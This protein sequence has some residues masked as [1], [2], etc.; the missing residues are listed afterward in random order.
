MSTPK[1]D[2]KVT[3]KYTSLI[4]FGT[5]NHLRDLT[6]SLR[7]I[8]ILS[9]L[10]SHNNPPKLR[11]QMEYTLW[12]IHSFKKLNDM[13]INRLSTNWRGMPRTQDRVKSPI[14]R[15]RKMLRKLPTWYLPICPTTKLG[16]I[17]NVGKSGPS[18]KPYVANIWKSFPTILYV[19][20]LVF[21]S[22][23]SL[24]IRFAR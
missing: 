1:W 14:S 16:Y 21:S 20:F 23:K 3:F 24:A 7:D 8:S 22:T 13:C 4:W 6:K 12:T 17:S 5:P 15:E 19:V 9:P 11:I 10:Q 2:L 18:I